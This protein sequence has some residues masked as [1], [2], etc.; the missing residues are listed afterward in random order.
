MYFILDD[1]IENKYR[2]KICKQKSPDELLKM[3]KSCMDSTTFIKRHLDCSEIYKIYLIC[4]D[5]NT[6]KN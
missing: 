5:N 3:Y 1:L 2:K 4:R 6:N